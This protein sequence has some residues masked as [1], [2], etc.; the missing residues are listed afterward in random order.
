MMRYF[1]NKKI[2]LSSEKQQVQSPYLCTD[3]QE[4]PIESMVTRKP[5]HL[6]QKINDYH[7]PHHHACSTG[8]YHSHKPV[9]NKLRR[10]ILSPRMPRKK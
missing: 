5:Q 4:I 6:P 8:K 9:I 1:Q 2:I 7:L 10:G 3:E